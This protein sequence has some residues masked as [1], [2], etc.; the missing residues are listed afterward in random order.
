MIARGEGR[1]DLKYTPM[2]CNPASRSWCY[3]TTLVKKTSHRGATVAA[4]LTNKLVDMSVFGYTPMRCNP[5]SRS[6]CYR[7]TL[8]KKTSHRGA[9][10]CGS[11]VQAQTR[12]HFIICAAAHF[13]SDGAKIRNPFFS[14]EKKNTARP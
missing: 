3:R 12:L 5:A 8:V 14:A 4:S 2:R 10:S 6:W 11:L 7:T 1:K 9:I 13:V